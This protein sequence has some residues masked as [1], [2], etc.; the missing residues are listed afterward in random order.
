MTADH[1]EKSQALD[2]LLPPEWTTDR[3]I[4]D[5]TAIDLSL[6]TGYTGWIL[7]L[8]QLIQL[9][10]A[11]KRIYQNVSELSQVIDQYVDFLLTHQLPLDAEK[12]NYSFFPTSIVKAEWEITNDV[13]WSTGDIGQLVLLY[14]AGQLLQRPEV[15]QCADRLS[16]Y[17][18][19]RRLLNRVKNDQLGL[20]DG[21]SGLSLV[22]RQ[23]F[24]LT[25]RLEFLTEGYYWLNQL[26][27]RIEAG[28]YGPDQSLLIGTLGIHGT[29][30][31]WLGKDI[32]LD[33]LFL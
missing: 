10:Q 21:V 17:L 14:K 32:S 3:P 19:Q 33:L 23:L 30:R 9:A 29:L 16:G 15:I 22:Y 8:L 5:Q 12:E 28:D 27:T 1:S 4:T 6:G 13:S 26:L 31:Q 18:L 20:T 24:L 11:H 25:N 7:T 2:R